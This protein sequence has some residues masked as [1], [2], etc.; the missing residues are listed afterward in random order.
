MFEALEGREMMSVS[1]VTPLPDATTVGSAPVT[2]PIGGRY[3]DT[4]VSNVVRLTTSQGEVYIGL[5]G[6]LAQATVNNFLAYVNGGRYNGTIFHRLTALSSDG[7]AVLQGGGF[8]LPTTNLTG[9]NTP[10]TGVPG[11]VAAF[12]PINLENPTGN[13]RYTLSMARTSLPNSA[14]SQFFINTADNPSLNAAGAN[15]GYAVFGGV[16]ASSRAVIDQLYTQGSANPLSNQWN[17]SGA[18]TG[19]PV[20][21]AF[22]QTPLVSNFNGDFPIKP[23]DYLSITTA[24][25]I[26]APLPADV[27]IYAGLSATSSNPAIATAAIVNG[28]LVVTPMPNGFGPVSITVRV[29]G[30]DNAF[31]DDTFTLNITDVSPTASTLQTRENRAVGQWLNIYA[32]GVRD[33]DRTVTRVDFYRDSNN[34]ATYDDGV[35]VQLGSDNSA[36]GGYNARVDTST[37]SAGANT[38][39]ARIVNSAGQATITTQTVNM[40]ARPAATTVTATSGTIT[41]E[42]SYTVVVTGVTPG[43]SNVRRVSVFLDTNN[44]STLNPFSDRLLGTATYNSTTG[45]WVFSGWGSSLTTGTNRLFIRVADIFGNLSLPQSTTVTVE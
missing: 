45:N 38:L 32:V 21:S 4:G 6:Q 34:N 20:A 18:F 29:T 17:I 13:V 36:A 24:D 23:S 44:D 39:F 28:Q 41:T 33:T 42:Q 10:V 1:I 22:S 7:I 31:V 2:I 11:Q 25:V 43:A 3:T 19:S 27:G 9:T 35:D 40:L 30:F 12:A 5:F 16:F 26:A 15:A 8:T 37:F 14:T